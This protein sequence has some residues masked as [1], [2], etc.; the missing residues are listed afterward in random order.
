MVERTAPERHLRSVLSA[1]RSVRIDTYG[2]AMPRRAST[3]LDGRVVVI[4]G[5]ARGIGLATARACHAAGAR[6]ALSDVDPVAL[7][8]AAATLPGAM[9]AVLDVTDE[10]AYAD[11]LAR[12][13]D[14]L[15][16]V[17]VLVSNAGVM[18]LAPYVE[19]STGVARRQLD[20]N[21]VGPIIGSKLVLPGM[22][23]RRRGHLVMIASV[24][25]RAPCP[26]AVTYSATKAAVLGLT[27]SL[28]EELRGSGVTATAILPSM[29]ATELTA[30]MQ[31]TPLVPPA[32]P[33]QV[34]EA[35]V[36]SIL[37]PRAEITVPRTV[38]MILRA[39]AIAG[40]RARDAFNRS[41]GVHRLALDVDDDARR[42]YESRA[43]TGA[44]ADA[45]T[46]EDASPADAPQRTAA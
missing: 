22:L 34:A 32:Q 15:G 46:S 18:P 27:D 7:A 3:A 43:R 5:S 6:V 35:V 14:A 10:D 45:A 16:P 42:A 19:E 26:G 31:P 28:R 9:H 29:I 33:E 4:T 39:Q 24:A 1:H 44:P 8:A 13:A 40:R 2:R 12:V 38:G 30:G 37:R 36:S 41:L 25:G 11:Y 20:I 21:V 17:D 23:E